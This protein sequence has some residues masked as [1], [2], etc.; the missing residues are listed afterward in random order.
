MFDPDIRSG[1][2]GTTIMFT[3]ICS[4]IC[5]PLSVCVLPSGGILLLRQGDCIYLQLR[6]LP[7]FFQFGRREA[8]SM[9]DLDNDTSPSRKPSNITCSQGTGT[10]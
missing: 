9:D 6:F 3:E 1:P 7:Y 8:L 2:S 4:I 5:I 10:G